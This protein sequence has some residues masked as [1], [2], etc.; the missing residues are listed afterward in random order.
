M[1]KDTGSDPFWL[2]H[3]HMQQVIYFMISAM[4]AILAVELYG[5]RSPD[6]RNFHEAIFSM[7][8]VGFL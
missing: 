4:Y 1:I 7:Y 8:Q 5:L 6:F 2:R 3:V